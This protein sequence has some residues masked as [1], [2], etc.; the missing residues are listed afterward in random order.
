MALLFS[1]LANPLRDSLTLD[2]LKGGREGA[3]AAETT[4]VGQ[5]LGSEGTHGGDG[6]LVETLE[7]G[8]AQAVDI[9]IVGDALLSEILAEVG[10]VGAYFSAS[11]DS[12]RSC[13]R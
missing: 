13:C 4:L 3:V 11:C 10:A 5:L 9:G 1:L 6:N 2:L 7:M 12:V 8:Y